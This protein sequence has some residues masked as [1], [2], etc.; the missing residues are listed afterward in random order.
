MEQIVPLWAIGRGI[1]GRD[2]TE[3]FCFVIAG[4]RHCKKGVPLY[5]RLVGGVRGVGTVSLF[6][7]VRFQEFIPGNTG[8]CQ[9]QA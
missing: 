1:K 5:G 6:L 3:S 9:D 2:G 4:L 8:L 7:L